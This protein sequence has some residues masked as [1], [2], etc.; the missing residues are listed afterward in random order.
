M[1]L[2]MNTFE[3]NAEFYAQKHGTAM[4]TKMAPAYANLSWEGLKNKP[5]KEPKQ[6]PMSGGVTLMIFL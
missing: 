1:I 5:W 2:T 4:G 6:N 3:F